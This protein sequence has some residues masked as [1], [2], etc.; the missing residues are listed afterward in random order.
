MQVTFV[1]AAENGH[2]RA[3]V[4]GAPEESATADTRE[5]AVE[6]LRSRLARRATA[7]ELVTVDI[8]PQGVMAFAN[9]K[10]KDDPEWRRLWQDIK[11][12]AYLERDEEK[13]REFPG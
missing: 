11:R 13:A 2:Y 5:A 9:S 6:A 7:G 1:V 12:Q 3:S 10:H 8:E 4:F